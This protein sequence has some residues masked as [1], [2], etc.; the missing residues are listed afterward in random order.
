MGLVSSLE[1][2]KNFKKSHESQNTTLE[3]PPSPPPALTT[4]N[5]PRNYSKTLTTLDQYK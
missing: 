1:V 3:Y 2:K 5:Y 4:L